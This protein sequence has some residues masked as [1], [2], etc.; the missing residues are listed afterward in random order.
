MARNFDGWKGLSLVA[1]C[2]IVA[3]GATRA[4]AQWSKAASQDV[5]IRGGWLFDGVHDTRSRNRGIVIRGGKF[6]EVGVD[7]T[8]RSFP[9]A[10]V[11]EL[12]DNATILPG[13]FDLHAHYNMDL[14]DA[15]RT[16][17][18][19][20]NPIVF[21]ANGVTATWTAGEFFP[22]R[23]IEARNRVDRGDAIGTRIFASG[24][25]FGAFRCEYQ[26]KTAADDCVAWPNDITEAE[27]RAEVDRW[28]KRGVTSIKIKQSTPT[29]TRILI[30][31]AK[32]HGMTTSGHLANYDYV[33][34]VEAKDAIAMG[35]DRIEHWITLEDGSEKTSELEAMIALFLK[36]GAFFDANL[37][38][39]GEGKLR[40]DP[41]LDMVWHDESQYF[42]SYT[43][44]LL[45]KRA[46]ENPELESAQ[47]E[48]FPQRIVELKA[49]YDAGGGHLILVGTDEPVYGLL[50]PG[51]AYHRELQAMVHAGLPPVAVL[52]A[53][54]L[55]GARALGVADRLGSIEAG[56]EADLYVAAGNPLED[57]KAARDV[58]LVVK[59]GAVYDPKALLASARDGIGPKGADDH[60]FWTLRV[61]P[62]RSKPISIR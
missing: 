17:E 27:I 4:N 14:V 22:D 62:L 47:P 2:G 32:K 31:R 54:T 19:V 6:V 59:A 52:K 7:L 42:T 13:M 24:P 20:Y 34:D 55:N 28:A 50:L 36:H 35:M 10:K 25:Y 21:L 23:V 12:D 41:S 43:R 51:F 3:L 45:K 15:G 49:F 26:I 38:M 37:Q 53:A 39:Y 9:G 5:V 33:Y 18:V 16:E 46:A 11:I 60:A 44:E 56:K 57:I 1:F 8:G 40:N 61:E 30:D 29:E 58:Q 48:E